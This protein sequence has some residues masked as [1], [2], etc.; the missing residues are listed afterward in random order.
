MNSPYP[1]IKELDPVW[2]AMHA[3][4]KCTCG[5]DTYEM[6]TLLAHF[7]LKVKRSGVQDSVCRI[8]ETLRCV[9]CGR[10]QQPED[11]ERARDGG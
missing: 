9:Q 7:V 3:R 4:A 10:L 11:L 5:C 1:N 2:R 6:V 8:A